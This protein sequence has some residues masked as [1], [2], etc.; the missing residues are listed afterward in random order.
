MPEQEVWF[1]MIGLR[2]LQQWFGIA[3]LR[4]DNPEFSSRCGAAAAAGDDIPHVGP[5]FAHSYLILISTIF[6]MAPVL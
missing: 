2:L 6:F 4:R 3:S 1:A 5:V